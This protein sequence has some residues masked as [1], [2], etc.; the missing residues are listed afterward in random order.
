MRPRGRGP[1]PDFVSGLGTEPVEGQAQGIEDRIAARLYLR[2]RLWSRLAGRLVGLLL[3][4]LAGG[5]SVTA[6]NLRLRFLRRGLRRVRVASRVRFLLRVVLLAGLVSDV[7][8][9]TRSEGHVAS[10]PSSG[11]PPPRPCPR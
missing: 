1:A 5:A 7:G 11:G 4:P 8:G 10:P 3:F 2:L 9:I 6:V